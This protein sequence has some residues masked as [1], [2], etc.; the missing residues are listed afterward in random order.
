MFWKDDENNQFSGGKKRKE[1]ILKKLTLN[2]GE[3]RYRV[4]LVKLRLKVCAFGS[5]YDE[6]LW[7]WLWFFFL[8]IILLDLK[9]SS[10]FAKSWFLASFTWLF[11][12]RKID[13]LWNKKERVKD[14]RQKKKPR[15]NRRHKS[16]V[17]KR[18]FTAAHFSPMKYE[19]N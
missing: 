11:D 12:L 10:F 3:W 6:A 8:N 7:I 5:A 4:P 13:S 19:C 2:S 9:F 15:R 17:S 18:L 1:E 16:Y 14:H